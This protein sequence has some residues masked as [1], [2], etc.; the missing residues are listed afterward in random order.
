[1]LFNEDKISDDFH[2]YKNNKNKSNEWTVERG[3]FYENSTYP[4]RL[5]ARAED[6]FKINLTLEDARRSCG[7]INVAIHLPS[8]IPNIFLSFLPINYGSISTVFI[9]A[10]SYRTDDALRKYSADVRKCYFEGERKLEFFKFYSKAH[11]EMEC[12]ANASI[13]Y[14]GCVRF[15]YPRNSTTRI[16]KFSE[17]DCVNEFRDAFKARNMD[18][19]CKCYPACNDIQYEI[20]HYPSSYRRLTSVEY[21]K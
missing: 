15:W 6:F 10:K 5:A 1:M 12:A 2:C 14:C 13:S 19:E 3:Y 16:C 17:I 9:K 8:E 4:K 11:C 20:Q 7:S 21:V 18:S